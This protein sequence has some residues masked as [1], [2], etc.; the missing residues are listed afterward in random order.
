MTCY[1]CGGNASS[2]AVV[3]ECS[4]NTVTIPC[5]LNTFPPNLGTTHCY[6]AAATLKFPGFDD[7][8]AFVVKG[9][10]NCTGKTIYPSL[11][12][13]LNNFNLYRLFCFIDYFF[14]AD[15]A[16]A[17][18]DLTAVATK[19]FNAN[20]TDFAM[21][22]CTGDNCNIQSVS[23][24]LPQVSTR[25]V[26]TTPTYVTPGIICGSSFDFRVKMGEVRLSFFSLC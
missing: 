9:C 1:S 13:N 21:E 19:Q 8:Q 7:T 18:A 14:H 16:A 10:I 25:P 5:F 11:L 2:D 23:A 3:A 15:I 4:S 22:C 26:S 6:I 17:R 24:V 12:Q 20:V